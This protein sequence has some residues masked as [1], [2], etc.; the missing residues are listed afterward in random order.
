[1]PILGTIILISVAVVKQNHCVFGQE[2]FL[3]SK[4][5]TLQDTF[6]TSFVTLMEKLKSFFKYPLEKMERRRVILK[7]AF[8]NFFKEATKSED[9]V[10]KV[11]RMDD[12]TG[13]KMTDTEVLE[14]V[15]LAPQLIASHGFE[16]ETHTVCTADDYV[17]T[18]HRILPKL[19]NKTRRTDKSKVALL[20]HGLFGSSDDW[21]LLGPQ[22]ALPYILSDSGYDVWLSNAR[23]NRY[24]KSHR[25]INTKSENFWDFSW[26]EIGKYD[27]SATIDYI[28]TITKVTSRID[29]IG[30]SMGATSLLV[31]LSTT[32]QYNV[33]LN[34]ATLLAPLV[35]MTDTK[36]PLR[37]F[38]QYQQAF[39]HDSLNFL[40]KNE[41]GPENKTSEILIEKFCKGDH[42]MCLNPFILLANGGKDLSN[43]SLKLQI[44][45]H[46]PAGGSTKTLKH[47]C[48]LVKSGYFHEYY[49]GQ[50]NNI[51]NFG[52]PP[53]AY[54]LSSVIVPV[55]IF[56]SSDDWLSTP[57]DVV[58][59]LSQLPN[60]LYNSVIRNKRFSHTDF[61]WSDD[62]VLIYRKLLDILESIR[63]FRRQKKN[64]EEKK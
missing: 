19:V 55:I 47:Y 39:G 35:F 5:T 13:N 53:L 18:L 21:I 44:L 9:D 15:T 6:K 52:T 12:W 62:A 46:V 63:L 20:H 25:K 4:I 60:V 45:N 17:L 11:Y 33:V 50:N 59:L 57:S 14:S 16:V 3:R 10:G 29:F 7:N 54:D 40:G 42:A 23:G 31:L 43:D 61:V 58:K 1:M 24:S 41:F 36:G 28:R 2:N 51:K 32:P 22:K 38:S 30:H 34:S 27:L 8:L 48:Q 26:H 37:I 56:S 64:T 49:S